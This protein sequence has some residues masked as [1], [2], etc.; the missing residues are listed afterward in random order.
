MGADELR[1]ERRHVGK[2]ASVES[3]RR[4]FEDAWRASP[5]PTLS[6]FLPPPEHPLFKTA[7][8]QLVALDLDWQWR[9]AHRAFLEK[10]LDDWPALKTDPLAVSRL[11]R[12]ECLARAVF[13][14]A[15]TREELER[16]F[17]SCAI[18]LEAIER[19]AEQFRQ[20]RR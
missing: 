4:D 16:R 19:E 5:Q 20:E 12:Q 1:G 9:S 2:F 7:L 15:P 14:E 8:S 10:Y 6:R 13:H 3:L 17:P 18:D 11:L